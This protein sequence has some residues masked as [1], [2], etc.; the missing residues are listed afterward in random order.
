[1][2]MK[3]GD[4]KNMDFNQMLAS[5]M[6]RKDVDT[7]DNMFKQ[8]GFFDKFMQDVRHNPEAPPSKE[9]SSKGNIEPM[10]ASLYNNKF[11]YPEVGQSK[12]K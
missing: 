5:E 2:G 9:P 8:A 1:M 10:M 3:P 4:A 11:D 12:R 6:K 7:V